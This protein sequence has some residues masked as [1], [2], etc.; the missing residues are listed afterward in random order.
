[1]I[2]LV[3][4]IAVIPYD[5]SGHELFKLEKERLAEILGE[6]ALS[7]H[8]IGSTAIP[9]IKA[10]PIIDILVEVKKIETIDEFNDRMLQGGYQPRGENGIPG[11]RFFIKNKGATRTHNV[12][13]FQTGNPEIERHLNFRDYLIAHPE[14]AQAYSNLKEELAQKFPKDILN[15]TTGKD[16]FIKKIDNKAKTWKKQMAD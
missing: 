9:N 10:K 8:H 16:E 15:Y 14:E 6:Q 2:A 5:K 13:M 12:H 7:I 1:M 4:K 11:R 3:R